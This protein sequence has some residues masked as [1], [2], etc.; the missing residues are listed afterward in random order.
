MPWEATLHDGP[1]D[2][3]TRQVGEEGHQQPPSTHLEAGHR[4]ELEATHG[5]RADYRYDG[6][7]SA[8]SGEDGAPAPEEQA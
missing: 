2:G 3:E 8:A 5:D 7:E 1:F 6:D 4:Y